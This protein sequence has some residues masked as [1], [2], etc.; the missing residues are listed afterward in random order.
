MDIIHYKIYC[1]IS[2]LLQRCY[3]LCSSSNYVYTQSAELR[4]AMRVTVILNT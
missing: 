1:T 2:M 3:L 4:L